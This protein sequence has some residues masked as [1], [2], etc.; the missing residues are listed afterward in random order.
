MKNVTLFLTLS[1]DTTSAEDKVKNLEVLAYKNTLDNI[2][3][4]YIIYDN[5]EDSLREALKIVE[6]NDLILM[7][8]AQGMD[9]GKKIIQN[10]LKNEKTY[11]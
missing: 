2:G 9:Q 4:K 11:S 1:K 5:L 7:L 3:V 6:K 8:G 10:I